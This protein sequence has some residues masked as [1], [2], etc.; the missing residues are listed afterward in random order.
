MLGTVLAIGIT[1]FF[2]FLKTYA[3]EESLGSIS[4]FF[5]PFAL[6][7]VLL[8]VFAG[9]VPDRVGP[10]RALLPAM[11]VLLVGIVVLGAATAG[12]HVAMAGVLCGLGHGYVFPILSALIIDRAP[13]GDRGAAVTLFTALFDVGLLLGGPSLGW[14][15]ETWGYRAMFGASALVLVLGSLVFARWDRTEAGAAT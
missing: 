13:E 14:V 12:W 3:Q 4:T 11:S 10:R 2:V 6:T 5:T 1:S 8:R 9:W 7:A 15:I